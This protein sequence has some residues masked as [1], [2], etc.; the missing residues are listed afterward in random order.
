M[1][2]LI[3]VRPV[4]PS[5]RTP[6]LVINLTQDQWVPVEVARYIA[7][8]IEGARLAEISGTDHV[9]IWQS[10]DE[11]VGEIEEFLTGVRPPPEVDRLLATV[12]FTDIVGS[13][14]IASEIGDQRWTDLLE[15]HRTVVRKQ[16]DAFRGTE[17]DTAGDGFLA[18]FDGPA[19]GVRCAQAIVEGTHA[20]GVDVRAGLHTGEIEVTQGDVAGIAVHIGQRVSALAGPGEVLVSRT[21]TDL[22][23]GSGLSFLDR[24]EH[25]LKGIAGRWQLYAVSN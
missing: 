11:V 21:I 9:F 4:L 8:R 12:L 25:E 10:Q 7:E 24:G 23:A 19:R 22:V 20:I 14:Q 13:T 17:I 2:Y 1:N 3:D 16:L 5:I 15:K 18:T 6:T